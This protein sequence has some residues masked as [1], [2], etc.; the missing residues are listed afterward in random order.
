MS[1]A[2]LCKIWNSVESLQFAVSKRRAHCLTRL[3]HVTL[4]VARGASTASEHGSCVKG[5]RLIVFLLQLEFRA[6]S[7]EG[8]QSA[9]GHLELCK[10]L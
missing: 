1:L 5:W 7:P 2:E 10:C 8:L 4:N 9:S 3:S 6:E